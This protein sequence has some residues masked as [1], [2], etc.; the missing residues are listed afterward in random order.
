MREPE[1]IREVE[2]LDIDCMG[3]IFYPRSPRFVS[4]D[5]TTLDAIRRCSRKKVGVFV[6]ETAES[7][8]QKAALYRLDYLQLHGAESPEICRALRTEGYGVI[9]SFSV[10]AITDIEKTDRYRENVDYLL[11]DTKSA[12]YG[13]SG[14][15]FDWSL[16]NEYTGNIPFLL[17]GGLSPDCLTDILRFRHPQFAGVDLNSGFEI[18]PALKDVVKLRDFSTALRNISAKNRL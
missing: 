14:E 2:A 13:G 4:D 5:A 17:S 12:G 7:I 18:S 16:L 10:G 9:K 8:R 3:F 11:F 15:R 1:N 6:D